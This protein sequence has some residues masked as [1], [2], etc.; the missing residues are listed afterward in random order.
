MEKLIEQVLHEPTRG[1]EERPQAHK[2]SQTARSAAIQ[3][4]KA[5]SVA[6]MDAKSEPVLLSETKHLACYEMPVFC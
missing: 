3:D 5:H 6:P 2:P 1:D 4:H